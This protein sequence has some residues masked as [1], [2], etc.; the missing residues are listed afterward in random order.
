MSQVKDKDFVHKFTFSGDSLHY[1]L[2]TKQQLYDLECFC[3]DSANFSAFSIDSTFD[4]GNFFVTN[5][6][7]ENK[8]VDYANGR[9]RGRHPMMMGPTF[10]HTKQET[11]DYVHFFSN[12]VRT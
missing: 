6:C 9:Y 12:A 2:A 10:I 8:R 11:N 5:T 7:F 1:A 4:V 3:T